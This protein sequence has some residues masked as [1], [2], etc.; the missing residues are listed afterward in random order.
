VASRISSKG[1]EVSPEPVH[2]RLRL[3]TGEPFVVMSDR[4]V[5]ILETIAVPERNEF[6][7]IA[8][9]A[10]DRYAQQGCTRPRRPPAIASASF[11]SRPRV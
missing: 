6:G 3:K 5:A 2:N 7:T 10:A 8:T 1:Q 11:E 4:E 9:R